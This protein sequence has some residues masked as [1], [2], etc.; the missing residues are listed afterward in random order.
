M[1]LVLTTDCKYLHHAQLDD[2]LTVETIF[3][4]PWEQNNARLRLSHEIFKKKHHVEVALGSTVLGICDRK[5][6]LQ[7]RLPEQVKTYLRDQIAFFMKHPDPH[8]Q[9]KRIKI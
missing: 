5:Y 8:V 7:Y 1:F 2:R 3:E 4:Y 6:K 9:I